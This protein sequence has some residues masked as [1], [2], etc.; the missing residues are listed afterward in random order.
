MKG[1]KVFNPYW[2]CLDFQ[3]KVGMSYEMDELPVCCCTGFHFCINLAE[4][5]NY[6]TFNSKNKVAEIEAYGEIDTNDN[7]K[8][9]TNKIKIVR[10]LSWKEVLKLV[11]TGVN[12]NGY[13]NIGDNNDGNGNV[14]NS[15]VDGG[16]TGHHNNGRFNSGSCNIGDENTGMHNRGNRNTGS[17]NTGTHNTGYCNIGDRNTGNFN[18]GDNN[19]GDWN[20]SNF[21]TGVF[22]T[23]EEEPKIFM[24]N[25]PSNMTLADWRISDAKFIMSY[26]PH[27]F[28]EW[29][30]ECYMSDKEKKE[31]PSYKTTGGY[32]KVEVPKNSPQK[33]WN[34]LPQMKKNIVMGL[35]N[36]N[37]DIFKKITG[38]EVRKEKQS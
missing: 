22:N 14:G 21:S 23:D 24:F 5:F 13:A 2:T 1:Y 34:N 36:F 32:L 6:Y 18:Y 33:W 17:Y 8:Y 9:C 30:S 4:C 15:N 20:I 31:N 28:V 35:P 29:I 3:Y 25:K 37:A 12:N 11:N 26:C 27:N 10:E 19:V 38:I 7:K 16:N